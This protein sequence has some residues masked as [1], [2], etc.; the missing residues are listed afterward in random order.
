MIWMRSLL[1]MLGMIL[2]TPV[3]AVIAILTFP[4]PAMLRYRII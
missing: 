2:F 4:L 1:F 3:Y